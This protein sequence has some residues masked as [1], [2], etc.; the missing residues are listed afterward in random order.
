MSKENLITKNFDKLEIIDRFSIK[1]TL[2]FKKKETF[3]TRI[4][5][6]LSLILMAF[7]LKFLISEAKRFI[8]KKN[9]NIND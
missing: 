9:Y 8:D 3:S 7:A 2:L 6:M 1:P 5:I 4:S